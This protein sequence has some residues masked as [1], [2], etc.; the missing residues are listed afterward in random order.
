MRMVKICM[1]ILCAVVLFAPHAAKSEEMSMQQG[2]VIKHQDMNQ[3]PMMQQH[4]M[5]QQP[6]H[7]M[8]NHEVRHYPQMSSDPKHYTSPNGITKHRTH[9]NV[10]Q[11]QQMQQMPRSSVNQH[12]MMQQQSM[13]MNHGNCPMCAKIRAANLTPEQRADLSRTLTE[14]SAE[15]EP[16]YNELLALK[17]EKLMMERSALKSPAEKANV[18]VQRE[19]L[20][21]QLMSN[22]KRQTKVLKNQYGINVTGR[23]MLLHRVH[24]MNMQ[25]AGYAQMSQTQ[26]TPVTHTH[27]GYRSPQS[28]NPN[29]NQ[30][31][32]M[33]APMREAYNGHNYQ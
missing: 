4:Q 31:Y 17:Q 21:K 5:Q 26:M 29:Y 9:P 11:R 16:L 6:Q 13:Y 33:N 14:F 30:Q 2:A 32:L 12:M 18:E 20:R 19:Q 24:E 3:Q 27:G 1:L 28:M 10:M 8:M 22:H 23:D 25:N 7:G 15:N